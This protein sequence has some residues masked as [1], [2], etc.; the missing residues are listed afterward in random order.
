MTRNSRSVNNLDHLSF[1]EAFTCLEKT[2]QALE[3]GG[4]TLEDATRLFEEGMHL[5]RLCNELLSATELKVTRLQT[6]FGEQ[7]RFMEKESTR[8]Q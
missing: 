7:M 2:V 3:A 5:A 1:E 4:L 6:A 8:D